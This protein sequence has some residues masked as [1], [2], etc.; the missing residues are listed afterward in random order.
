MQQTSTAYEPYADVRRVD[1]S[2]SFG[3]V[4]PEAA[5]LAQPT[6]VAQS[7]VSQIVQTT[8]GVE[9]MGGKYTTLERNMW[10]LDGTM[11]L[12]PA[13]VAGVQTGWQNNEISSDDGTFTTTPWLEFEFSQDIDSYGF[14][15]IFDNTMPG[16]IPAQVVTTT[17]DATG[18]QI[19]TLT[20]TSDDYI[21]IV[22]LA[23][24]NYRRVRFEFPKT[25]IPHRR[26]RVCGVRF[27]II[28][29][30]GP[31][32]IVDVTV[33][34]SVDPICENLASS[35]LDATIDNSEQL[36]NMINP[37]GL[38]AYLQDGQYMDWQITIGNETVKMGRQYFTTA[39]SDDGG[40]TAQIT[41]NDRLLIMD[42]MVFDDG[43]S[44]TWPLSTAVSAILE[45]SGTG[46]QAVF[47]GATGN[48]LI[49][50]CIPQNTKIREAI[51]L[52]AQAAM[53][54]CY[55]DR[56]NDLHFAQPA[57][58]ESDAV[59][60]WT[61]D[62]MHEDAQVKVGEYYNVVRLTSRDEFA[63]EPED[64]VYTAQNVADG[65]FERIF[66]VD[67]P[68]V[69]SGQEVA[70]WILSWVQRRV[71]YEVTTRG[72]PAID[73]LDIVQINDVYGVNGTGVITE[74]NYMYDGG[75]ECDAVA[76]R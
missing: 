21:H 25:A 22:N 41:F 58:P 23:S 64:E 72:N 50:K 47:D 57:A 18:S 65:D 17:Y 66:E 33:R 20:T 26:I 12:Y 71:S 60:I 14:T 73:L 68:L 16:D 49:R 76:V 38:Y 10:L 42:D 75:L 62:V 55:I 5:E 51:R 36:Y 48:T 30:Y 34:Q 53:C 70:N 24:Q 32:N 56:N 43:S 39:E 3:V 4:P 40:L 31:Q 52:C 35:E 6:S 7:S 2:F 63:E 59:E 8:D 69:N 54:T 28:Y 45:A 37:S 9:Q 61:Q 19:G 27:G 74:L 67:N 15:L 44:G 11:E 13:N 1:L 29:D 46:I